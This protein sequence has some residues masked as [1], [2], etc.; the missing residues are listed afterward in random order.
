MQTMTLLDNQYKLL[1]EL[2]LKERRSLKRK[3]N[4]SDEDVERYDELANVF[5]LVPWHGKYED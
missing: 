1:K 3:K 5:G 2:A 4:A